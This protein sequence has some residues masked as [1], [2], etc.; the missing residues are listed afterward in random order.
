MDGISPPSGPEP[1]DR[2]TADNKHTQRRLATRAQLLKAARRLMREGR[3]RTASTEEISAMAGVS[4]TAFYLHFTSKDHL[5]DVLQEDVSDWYRRQFRKLDAEAAATRDGLV[6]W[7]KAF[8]KGLASAQHA[9]AL[10]SGREN[11]MEW[12][13]GAQLRGEAM[14]TLASQIPAMRLVK[15]DGRICDERRIRLLL[16]IFQ[17]E[18][19]C[20][21]IALSAPDEGDLPLEIL[22]DE[23]LRFMAG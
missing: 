6:A 17:V 11:G 7:F 1:A 12:F 15:A 21:Y 20:Q 23:F 2:L 8:L 18:Q 10:L 14:L 13:R 3:F 9:V 4:R 16:L 5:L 19:L 22:A